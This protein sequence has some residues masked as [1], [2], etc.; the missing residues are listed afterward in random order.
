MAIIATE[1]PATAS[2]SDARQ[3]QGQP[4]EDRPQQDHL[5]RKHPHRDQVPGPPR[6]GE[7]IAVWWLEVDSGF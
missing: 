6:R 3:G 1:E 2:T 7:L 5:G 4:K